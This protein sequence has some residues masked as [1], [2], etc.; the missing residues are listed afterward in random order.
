[1]HVACGRRQGLRCDDVIR[2]NMRPYRMFTLMTSAFRGQT[3]PLRTLIYRY[4]MMQLSNNNTV[5]QMY[6]TLCYATTTSTDQ[7]QNCNLPYDSRT[8]MTSCESKA[9]PLR[10]ACTSFIALSCSLYLMLWKMHSF[11]LS[12]I[13]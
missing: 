11:Q 4:N 13:N 8:P 1:M 12:S 2:V 7:T 3:S 9:S 5:V 10:S 6:S